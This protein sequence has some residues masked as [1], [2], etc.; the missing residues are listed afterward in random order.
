MTVKFLHSDDIDDKTFPFWDE[1]HLPRSGEH[2]RWEGDRKY[3][4]QDVEWL[5][6]RGQWTVIFFLRP[7]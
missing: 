4:I 2:I 7:Q 3:K 6:E 5:F 1:D